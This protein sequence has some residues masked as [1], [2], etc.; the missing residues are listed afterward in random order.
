MS[1][2]KSIENLDR[3]KLWLSLA[4]DGIVCVEVNDYARQN[5][6]INQL[7]HEFPDRVVVVDFAQKS[8]LVV[9][10][11]HYQTISNIEERYGNGKILL[12][13]NIAKLVGTSDEE[14]YQ[15]VAEINMNRE[16]YIRYNGSV[17]F[18]FPV[19]FMELI[20]KR[21]FDF[22]SMMRLRVDLSDCDT[23]ENA[24]IGI[25]I[26][27]LSLL[28]DELE[29]PNLSRKGILLERLANVAL[30]VELRLNAAIQ[31]LKLCYYYG[32]YKEAL[33]YLPSIFNVIDNKDV[34][35]DKINE[36][37]GYLY[38]SIIAIY[39]SNGMY[40]KAIE[41]G[42]FAIRFNEGHFGINHYNTATSYGNTAHAY[43]MKSQ[44][45]RALKYYDIAIKVYKDIF[46]ES[47]HIVA[48]AYNN[49]AL[50]Y[51]YANE[52][53]KALE[54]Y[55]LA[56]KINKRVLGEEH[57]NTAASCINIANSYLNKLQFDEALK[58]SNLALSIDEKVLGKEH[59]DTASAYYVISIAYAR[60]G[61]FNK[62]LDYLHLSLEI[63]EKVF[64]VEH[65]DTAI[66]FLNLARIS[67]SMGQ[68]ETALEWYKKAYPTYVKTYGRKDKLTTEIYNEMKIVYAKLQRTLSFQ[69]W[70]KANFTFR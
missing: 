56:L 13:T 27:P 31:L 26:T 28:Y 39:D 15:L 12:F 42:E 63:R 25:S 65:P 69:K 19:Y 53:D 33:G 17:V 61:E 57:P 18:L 45:D 7:E 37:V 49:I 62:A 66:T 48:T 58:Y 55:F 4:D 43:N 60:K 67:N 52:V 64:G 47:H 36:A 20:L 34:D 46:G 32:L 11:Q 30:K 38:N 23:G 3:L 1:V 35:S 70:F 9:P 8:D 5:F 10:H 24:P 44:Y 40:K 16:N 22:V 68:Y 2:N 51:K 50:V 41:F 6:I 21:A 59:P 29:V 14:R 54:L